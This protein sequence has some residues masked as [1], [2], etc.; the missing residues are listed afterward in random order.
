MILSATPLM[1]FLC[2]QVHAAPV[3]TAYLSVDGRPADASSVHV[4]AAEAGWSLAFTA[5]A[6]G[7]YQVGLAVEGRTVTPL[8]PDRREYT[9][10]DLTEPLVLRYPYDWTQTT[11]R[12]VMAWA[13]RL[14]MPGVIA[15]DRLFLVDTH[16]LTSVRIEAADD[17]V[18]ALLLVHRFE[19]RGWDVATPDLELSAGERVE[20][21]VLAFDSIEAANRA[22]FG[23]A[24]P[25]RASMVQAAYRGWTAHYLGADDYRTIAGRLAGA[26]DWLIAREAETHDWLPPLLHERGMKIIAYQYLGA[27]R[28]YSAQVAAGDEERLGMRGSGGEL[29]TAPRSPNGAWLLLDIR[30]PEMREICVRRAVEAVKAGFDGV[31]LDGTNLFADADGHR[32]GNVPGAE[33]SLAWAQWKLLSEITEAVHAAHPGAVVGCLGNNWYDAVNAAD[34]GLKERMYFSWDDFTRDFRRRR[35]LVRAD[36]DT[37]W[38]DGQAPYA[39]KGLAYGVKGVNPIGVQTARHFI[40][41]PTELSYYG[42]GDF[43]PEGLEE[44]LDTVV[45]I[46]T[47]DL[48]ITSVVPER[49]ALHFAGRDTLWSDGDC[50]ISTSRPACL[51]DASGGCLTHQVRDF[52]LTAGRRYR[53]VEHCQ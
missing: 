14:V 33:H 11:K 19:N 23:E 10:E 1:L 43:L 29:F 8:S 38:E 44:W 53:L 37:A 2:A 30:R 31:F 32:G 42:V 24:P 34:F 15:G 18:R 20:L 27:L 6:D 4:Q 12:N 41:R 35:T 26:F 22:R 7:V 45:S 52:R 36:M 51:L 47:C 9:R 48:Y 21:E 17:G 39:A 13:T 3:V 40:R 46:A 16:E 5:P 50:R 28:R 49:C 25:L